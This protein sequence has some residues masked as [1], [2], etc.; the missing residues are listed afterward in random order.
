MSKSVIR[1]IIELQSKSAAEMRQI[2]NEIMPKKCPANTNKEYLRPRISYRL[3][4]LAFG[5]LTEE[6]STKLLKISE[7]VSVNNLRHHSDLIPGTKVCREWQG[8][9]HEV[10]VRK[11]CYEYQGQKFRSLSAIARKITNTRW[12][13]LKFFKIK[14]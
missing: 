2:Y 14:S 12:N 6:N 8:V 10:E 13:G 7:G 11:D 3:Q 9:M 1:Q 4:E 5:S